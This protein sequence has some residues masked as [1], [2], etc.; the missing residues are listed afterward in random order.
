MGVPG[1]DDS[2]AEVG[3]DKALGLEIGERGEEGSEVLGEKGWGGGVFSGGCIGRCRGRFK[4]GRSGMI[5]AIDEGGEPEG[6]GP[7][8]CE[9]V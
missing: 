2:L 3:V 8:T 5:C 4:G 1:V 6:R 7:E 9:S